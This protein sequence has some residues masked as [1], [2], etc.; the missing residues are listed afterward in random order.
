MRKFVGGARLAPVIGLAAATAV[1]LA[2]E[3]QASG[4]QLK[5]QSAEGLGNA[6]AGSTAKA[7]DLST[8]FF[9]PAG[10]TAL[11]GHQ[12]QA[13]TS[14]I[15]PRAE[16][17]ADSATFAGTGTG[18]DGTALPGARS[19]DD[20][21]DDAMIPAAYAM[22]DVSDDWKI[23]LAVNVPFGLVTDYSDN[24]VGRYHALKSDLRT[25]AIQPSVAHKVNDWLSVGGGLV[26]QHAEAELTKAVDFG[27]IG[28]G[29]GIP[30]LTPGLNDGKTKV[31]GEDFS[32]GYTLGIMLQPL[33][34]TRVGL[35]YRSGITHELDGDV[36]FT[37]V[38]GPLANLFPNSGGRAELNLPAT[39][40]LGLYHEV[41]DQLALMGE[42]AWTEWSVFKE[43]SVF[44][45]GAATPLS[46]TV[47]NWDDTW[48]FSA[49]ATYEPTD[50]LKLQLGVAH[51]QSPVPDATR[52][53][54]VPDADRTWVAL[55]AGYEFMPGWEANL[56]YT[57]IWVD[58]ARI[59]LDNEG[60]N[61]PHEHRVSG[62]YE[63]AIDIISAQVRVKF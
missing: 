50:K 7:Q 17:E 30:G 61:P 11:S 63:S 24:W 14:Y 21:I 18:L 54:R 49:G 33:E 2:M 27:T 25:I 3:A 10:M 9:N 13:T 43:L 48:F 36:E 44:R 6:F 32:V 55:G 46:R 1:G 45:Q 29:F 34:T 15:I 26:V 40:S 47:E 8:I 38:P 56:A 53:P 16:F 12:G 20:A 41:N 5:E 23:G 42:V 60:T 51:D 39:A 19:Q 62:K 28:A 4:F 57:H 35:S 31:T 52:T 22:Y 59:D 58:E 37:G